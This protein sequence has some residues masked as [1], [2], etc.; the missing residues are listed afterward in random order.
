[1]SA[2]IIFALSTSVLALL[3]MLLLTALA[4]LT[5]PSSNPLL[6]FPFSSRALFCRQMQCGRYRLSQGRGL[7]SVVQLRSWNCRM[8]SVPTVPSVWLVFTFCP[9]E[10][11]ARARLQ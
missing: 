10:T 2:Y 4:L 5:V 11:D 8:L 7:S 6:V 3:Y 1:M 9:M